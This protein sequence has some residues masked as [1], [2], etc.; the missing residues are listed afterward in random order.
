MNH[1]KWSGFVLFKPLTLRCICMTMMFV[2]FMAGR[3]EYIIYI[4]SCVQSIRQLF[5]LKSCVLCEH[6]LSS[7]LGICPTCQESLPWKDSSFQCQ[8]C[9]Q[10]L[11]QSGLICGRCLK[12]MPQFDRVWGVFHYQPAIQYLLGAFKFRGQ[13]WA[14]GVLAQLWSRQLLPDDFELPQCLVPVPLSYH[15]HFKRGF[16]QSAYFAYHLGRAF[17][18]PVDYRLLSRRY[19]QHAQ[20]SLTLAQRAQHVRQAFKIRAKPDVEHIALVDDVLTSG[21]TAHAIAQICKSSGV[22]Q[23]DVWCLARA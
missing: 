2:V 17:D 10:S 1:G 21:A 11:S 22:K 23:V 15:R 4:S 18:L 20:S 3:L 5:L 8:R 14:G 19:S 13:M 9:A 7:S 12:S 16:N 6:W